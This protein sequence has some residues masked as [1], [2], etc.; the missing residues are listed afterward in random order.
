VELRQA[1]GKQ[2]NKG[3]SENRFAHAVCFGR[4]QESQHAE[5]T[6]QD[7]ADGCNRLTRNAIVCWNYLYLSHV[8][9]E[10]PEEKRRE[11]LL[12]ALK[13]S[14]IVLWHH[15]NLHGKYDFSE[16]KFQDSEGLNPSRILAVDVP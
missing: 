4:S 1:V 14:T 3:E 5:K 10:E 2:L 11:A 8:L 7:M 16:E 9:A 12:T 13:Q 15:L 6:E